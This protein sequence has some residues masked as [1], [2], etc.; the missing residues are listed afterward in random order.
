MNTETS[1]ESA[2]NR[3]LAPKDC[4]ATDSQVT[5]LNVLTDL[6]RS[7]Q[8]AY[9][10][11]IHS[12]LGA[13][14]ALEQKP[15][16]PPQQLLIHFSMAVVTILGAGLRPVEKSLQKGE[17]QFVQRGTCCASRGERPPTKPTTIVTSVTITFNEQTP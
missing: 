11:F 16:A 3:L 8:L 6:Q 14:P 7:H 4:Y 12:E 5:T 17:L 9:A 1:L 10:H 15:T 2:D 13:N